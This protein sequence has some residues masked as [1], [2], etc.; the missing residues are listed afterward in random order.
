MRE[1][2]LV[3]SSLHRAFTITYGIYVAAAI[4]AGFSFPPSL[5]AVGGTDITRFW[6]LGLGITST[7]SLFFSLSETRQRKETVSTLL[8]VGFLAGYSTALLWNSGVKGNLDLLM[9]GVFTLS[10]V[11]FPVWRVQFFYRKFRK[12][13]G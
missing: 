3:D 9:V 5:E 12:P 11:V 2:V 1:P 7:F 4:V 6:L 13:R 10:F 8:L